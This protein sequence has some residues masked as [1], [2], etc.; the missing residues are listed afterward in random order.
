MLEYKFTSAE[1]NAFHRG[2]GFTNLGIR[3]QNLALKRFHCI[4]CKVIEIFA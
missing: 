2:F 1:Q 4:I 3:E